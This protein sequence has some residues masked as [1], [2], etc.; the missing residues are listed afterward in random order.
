MTRSTSTRRRPTRPVATWG[1][2]AFLV[3]LVAF[4]M[5]AWLVGQP[6]IPP[7]DTASTD[8]LH[9]FASPTL[10]ALMVG[11][12][13]LGASVVLA[14]VAGLA[15]VVLAVRRRR[16]EAV[17]VALALVGTLVLNEA[18]KAVFQRP[19]PGFAWAEVQSDFGFPSGH[20]MNSFVV[21]LA[22]A[23][24]AWRLGG[25]RVGTVALALAV[26]LA[27][28]IGISRIYLGAHWLTDVVGGY[29]AGALWLLCLVAASDGVSWLRRSRRPD[30]AARGEV[31]AARGGT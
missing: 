2:V 14:S 3:C 5:I 21:Y 7:I 13:G 1:A 28:S 11:V 20:T 6:G 15:A 27:V 25:R 30:A 17:F 26:M 24:V 10:D 18:L 16:A 8:V 23:F 4:G 9:G 29:L 22:L 12:T 31:T 19:R